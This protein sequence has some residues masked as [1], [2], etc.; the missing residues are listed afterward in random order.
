MSSLLGY[1]IFGLIGASFLLI[2]LFGLYGKLLCALS[3]SP[4]L[5]VRAVAR[6]PR[7]FV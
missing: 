2:I 4:R 7:R 6:R 3:D 5:P 1:C